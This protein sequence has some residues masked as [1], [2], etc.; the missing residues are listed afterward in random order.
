MNTTNTTTPE[1]TPDPFTERHLL[2]LCILLTEQLDT[3]RKRTAILEKREVDTKRDLIEAFLIIRK[4]QQDRA[5]TTLLSA[6]DQLGER[7]ESRLEEIR[8]VN[9]NGAEVIALSVLRSQ[10]VPLD[11]LLKQSL[12]TGLGMSEGDT[13]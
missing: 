4:M 6:I 8:D 7:L 12:A 9:S 13:I 5:D 3:L 2:P 11:G 10:H 1:D